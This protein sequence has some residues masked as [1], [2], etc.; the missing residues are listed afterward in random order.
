MRS[1]A[2][3]EPDKAPL[4]PMFKRLFLH[5]KGQWPLLLAAWLSMAAVA[6]LQF[7][8]PKLTQYAVDHVIPGKLYGQLLPMAGAV[9][10]TAVLLGVFG[11]IS[12]YT[13]SKAGQQTVLEIRN[14]LYRHLQS[15][16]LGFYDRRRTGDLMSRMT[17]DVNQL[18]QMVSSGTMGILTDAVTFIAIAGYM[19]LENAQMTVALLA[20]FPVMF[21]TARR[22]GGRMRRTFRRVQETVAE[23]SSHLQDTLSSI[24]LV[25]SFSAEERESAVF[26][27]LS[28]H[29]RDANLR[30][31]RFSAIFSPMIDL[32][33]YAG[34]A[35]VLAF[36]SWQAMR[37]DMTA[38]SVIAYLSYL[39]LLQNP[40]RRFSRLMSTVQQSAAAYDRIMET[41]SA[42]PDVKDR[43]DAGELRLAGGEIA[44]EQVSFRYS[45]SSSDV[46]HEF[47]LTLAPGKTTALVG[48][49]GAGKTTA[50]HLV[51]RYYDATRGRITIDGT[52]IRDV[53][54]ASLRRQIAI[55]SQDVMLRNGSVRANLTYGKPGAAEEEMISAAQAAYAHPFIEE[56]PDGYDTEVGER[57]VR[58]SGGQKQRLSIA[59]ALLADPK[60]IILDEATAS[61]DTESEQLIQ[62]ALETLLSGR[63]S[64]VIA[65]RLSTVRR[66]DLIVVMEQGRIVQ[67]GTHE[68]LMEQGGRYRHLYELQ[69]PQQA[70]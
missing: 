54:Q 15:L 11:Y 40:V 20:L 17:S 36:G 13:F 24:R 49:S 26:A 69:F 14:R 23:M 50:A 6:A 43:P 53:T 44:F 66:A 57:G 22:Y 38:G 30:S 52:D 33:Q 51:M 21:L 63:T 60:V 8:I 35:F 59:R 42:V 3:S 10:G 55:V 2:A 58:L 62:A 39:R 18:Q 1:H 29:N 31:T 48:S 41:M 32:L 28:A 68:E 7:V 37:G 12:S 67:S 16:D 4:W 56:L 61:L 19:L 46:L 45:S 47:N 25:K 5:V 64:L 9:L 34:M 27:R 70:G 65:H